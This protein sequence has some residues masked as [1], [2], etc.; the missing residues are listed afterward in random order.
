MLKIK[1]FT[2]LFYF[3]FILISIGKSQNN[4]QF[5]FVQITDSHLGYEKHN[6]LMRKIVYS[7]NNLPM[8]IDFIVHTG[9]IFQDNILNKKKTE[10][11]LEIFNKLEAPIYF[12]P[13]NHDI[14]HDNYS[15]THK[16]Y[17]EYFN[18][19]DTAF[20][21]KN[22][23][24]IFV[25]TESFRD[26]LIPNYNEKLKWFKETL[27]I[28][29]SIEKIVFHH[30][31]SVDDF[32]NN[33]MHNGWDNEKRMEWEKILNSNNVKAVIA[34]HFHRGEMHWLGDV[35]LYI[36]PSIAGFWGRQASYRIYTYDSGKLSYRTVYIQ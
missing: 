3:L 2:I 8:Q 36:S 10:T 23:Q 5:H 20:I 26:N 31:P 30:S 28:N 25:Y 12:V 9:D 6:I 17:I 7:I 35:P 34:G 11:A 22:I 21:H 16:A 32:Y 15:S 14:L 1:Y 18:R 27:N 29:K 19:T 24:L 13:G 33:K 4:E